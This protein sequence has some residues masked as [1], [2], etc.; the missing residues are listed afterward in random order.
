MVLQETMLLFSRAAKQLSEG[1]LACWLSECN[2]AFSGSNLACSR[3]FFL[4]LG[5]FAAAALSVLFSVDLGVDLRV[6]LGVVFLPLP[7]GFF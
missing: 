2:L 6:D 4:L 1:N 5:C 7:F 3:F